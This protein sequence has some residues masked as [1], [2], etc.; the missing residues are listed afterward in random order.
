MAL[1]QGHGQQVNLVEDL[2]EA[3]ALCDPCTDL[4]NEF[5]GHI[6]GAGFAVF[7]A[8]ELLSGMERPP[9]MT[10][11]LRPTAAMGIGRERS[12]E[13]WGTEGDFFEPTGNHAADQRGMLRNAHKILAATGQTDKSAKT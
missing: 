2:F 12:S 11:A 1:D 3:A 13:D 4:R 8:G 9:T 10:A 6:D 7:L 5:L